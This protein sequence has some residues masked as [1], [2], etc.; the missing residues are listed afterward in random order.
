MLVVVITCIVVLV[1]IIT[2]EKEIIV[3]SVANMSV[4]D[5][6]KLLQDTGFT[7][8]DEHQ[9]QSSSEVKEG[10]VIKTNPL[11]GSKRTRN[12]E[13]V[14]YVSIGDTK[15]NIENYIGKTKEIKV[16]IE[17]IDFALFILYICPKEPTGTRM[18]YTKIKT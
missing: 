12:T 10:F 11:E 9:E 2:S 15:I 7:V 6:I 3:P 5:A 1:P 13:I 17:T 18:R 4:T 16:N 14:L 8:S